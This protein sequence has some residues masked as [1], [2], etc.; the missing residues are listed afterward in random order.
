M[1]QKIRVTYIS[2][3]IYPFAKSGESADVASSLPKYLSHL[4][5]QV[6][7][8]MPKYRRPEVESLSM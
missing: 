7:I 5:M 4:G 6:T 3:E 1:N 8:F 2:A